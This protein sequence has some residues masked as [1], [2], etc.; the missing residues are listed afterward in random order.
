MV[1]MVYSNQLFLPL[2]FINCL[3]SGIFSCL[4]K[5]HIRE[6]D[7]AIASLETVVWG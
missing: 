7:S 4:V 2:L 3:L 5:S 1:E 6:K